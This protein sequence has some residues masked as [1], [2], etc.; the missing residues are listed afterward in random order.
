MNMSEMTDF[1]RSGE[2]SGAEMN[3]V[4]EKEEEEGGDKELV[5]DMGSVEEEERGDKEL[6]RESGSVETCLS[7]SEEEEGGDK[8]LVRESGSVETGLSMSEEEEELPCASQTISKLDPF[9][10]EN[11]NYKGLIKFSCCHK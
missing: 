3:R 8:E 11:E 4:E 10:T 7:M 6:V 2:E 1:V 9:R 5:G